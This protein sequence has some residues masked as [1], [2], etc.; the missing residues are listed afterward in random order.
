MTAVVANSEDAGNNVTNPTEDD[1]DIK[2]HWGDFTFFSKGIN[3]ECVRVIFLDQKNGPN[4][5]TDV[6]GGE[7]HTVKTLANE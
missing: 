3:D 4:S 6:E 2:R 1:D 7:D 5:Q